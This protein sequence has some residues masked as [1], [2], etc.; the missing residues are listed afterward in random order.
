MNKNGKREEKEEEEE[1]ISTIKCSYDDRKMIIRL[2]T[3]RV[4]I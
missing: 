1:E 4:A 2:E 3:F